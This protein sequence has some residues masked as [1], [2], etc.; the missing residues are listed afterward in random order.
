MQRMSHR[1]TVTGVDAVD[2]S[3]GIDGM[4]T[5]NVEGVES[6]ARGPYGSMTLPIWRL[7]RVSATCWRGREGFRSLQTQSGCVESFIA[8]STLLLPRWGVLQLGCR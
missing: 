3:D 1:D 6:A 2:G 7:A 8:S 5:P 4:H